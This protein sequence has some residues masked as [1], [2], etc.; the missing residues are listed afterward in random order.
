MGISPLLFKTHGSKFMKTTLSIAVLSLVL[1]IV[2][3]SSK[4]VNWLWLVTIQTAH[5][6]ND[7]TGVFWIKTSGMVM[8]PLIGF[9]R[10]SLWLCCP[11]ERHETTRLFSAV[12]YWGPWGL[13]DSC[14]KSE[15]HCISFSPG[16][17]IFLQR[18][19]HTEVHNLQD[20]RYYF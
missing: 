18:G 1:V 7:E 14:P 17:Y 13:E 3:S 15:P 6:T 5:P 10:L 2:S 8:V 11:T 16:F 20:N 9:D 19:L 4:Q 12:L